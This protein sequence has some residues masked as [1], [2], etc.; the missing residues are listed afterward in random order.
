MHKILKLIDLCA[1]TGAFSH[2][3]EK[4]GRFKCVFANDM[5]T[6]SEKIYDLNHDT[7]LTNCDLNN[8]DINNI[9]KHHILCA[10][11]PCQAFSISG[12]QKGFD[13]LP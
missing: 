10:G 2:V 8:F 7:K 9:P 5:C 3:F 4:T 6:E 13:D 11:F 12:Q 1:G